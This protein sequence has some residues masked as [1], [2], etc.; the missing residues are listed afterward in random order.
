MYNRKILFPDEII[1]F[2][3]QNSHQLWINN[4]IASEKSQAKRSQPIKELVMVPIKEIMSNQ[5]V[6][7]DDG[8]LEVGLIANISS[9]RTASSKIK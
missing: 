9:W 2:R 6:I 3:P 8:K 7:Q 1:L 4:A 5:T